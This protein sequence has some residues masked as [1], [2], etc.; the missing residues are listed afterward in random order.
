M[1]KGMTISVLAAIVPALLSA[2]SGEPCIEGTWVQPIPGAETEIQG[3][4][5]EPDGKASS[6]NMATLLYEGWDL[7]GET[8]ILHGKSIGNGI[9]I[10]F[11][12]T[13]KIEKLTADS[14]VLSGQ[15][16]TRRYS[17]KQYEQ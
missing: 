1:K 4:R 12:D 3:L 6:V 17:R 15:G 13:M 9:T 7:D 11:R 2:C 8:L 14:L 10:D 5:L 16:D